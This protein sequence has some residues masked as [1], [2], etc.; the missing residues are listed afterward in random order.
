MAERIRF[1]L[2]EPV[3]PV[4]A[5][6]LRK[7]GIDV[8][9]TQEAGLRALPDA[10]QLEFARRERRVIVTQ[11]TDFLRIAGSTTDHPGIAFCQ[12]GSRS[13]GTIIERLILIYE[14]LTAEEIAGRVE[15]L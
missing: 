8:T 6:A 9:T 3:D 5:R 7:H 4:I 15:F 11:D 2:D 13:I 10:D 12:Q 1:H 14:V